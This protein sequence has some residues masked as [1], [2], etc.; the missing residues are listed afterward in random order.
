MRERGYAGPTIVRRLVGELVT[1]LR[2]GAATV[3]VFAFVPL[4]IGLRTHSGDAALGLLL[5]AIGLVV[6]GLAWALARVTHVRRK[7]LYRG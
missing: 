4:V 1:T 7:D 2:I 3:F 6:A 5:M